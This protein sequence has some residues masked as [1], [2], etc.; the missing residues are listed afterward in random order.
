MRGAH[1][2]GGRVVQ[3]VR[4]RVS[5]WWRG[6]PGEPADGLTWADAGAGVH[7]PAPGDVSSWVSA[8]CGGTQRRQIRC[9]PR[10][11]LATL[12][13]HSA[14]A[15]AG[16]SLA[17]R[18]RQGGEAGSPSGWGG[19]LAIGGERQADSQGDPALASKVDT[20][21]WVSSPIADGN[22]KSEMRTLWYLT[23]GYT[24]AKVYL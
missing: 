23:D 13:E 5:R 14:L 7:R 24:S 19:D 11:R 17:D 21:I 6:A 15:V 9:G 2:H 3:G 10:R 20:P 16:C 22:R 18:S 1:D 12:P 4:A 8:R